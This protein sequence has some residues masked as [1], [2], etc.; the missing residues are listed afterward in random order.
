M[1]F[2]PDGRNGRTS[3]AGGP[4]RLIRLRP[5]GIAAW[6][7]LAI[8]AVLPAVVAQA[9]EPVLLYVSIPPQAYLVEEIGGPDV[10]VKTLVRPGQEPHTFDATPKQILDLGR[11]EA[12][13]AIGL[14]FEDQ[15]LEKIRGSHHDLLIVD[16]AHG[17]ERVMIGEH[18]GGGSPGEGADGET[19]HGHGAAMHGKSHQEAADH[20]HEHHTHGGGK[21]PDP[22]IWLSPP[23]IE[24]LA[25]NTAGELKKIDPEHSAGYESRLQ[26]FLGAL[27]EVDEEIRKILEPYRGQSFYVF[28]PAFGYFGDAY[29]LDQVAVETGG[30][31]PSPRQL[32]QLI[33]RAQAD[34]VKIIFVQPQF[35]QRS[36]RAVAEA[37]G[38]AVVPVDPLAREILPN[39]KTLAQRMEEA[40]RAQQPD[41]P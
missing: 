25:R 7:I 1:M 32:A 31:S 28:H 26:D 36:A 39:L 23:L 38:G 29:G 27:A 18:E 15:L 20:G 22:H 33:Q 11:A 13:F 24:Q 17:I 37:I 41:G 40:L 35:D 3:R 6:L 8:A 4:G 14:P 10:A 21:H 34:N 30:K 2:E 16:M 9:A 12:Y 19:E 5:A